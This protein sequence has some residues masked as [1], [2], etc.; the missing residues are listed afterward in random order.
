MGNLA[1]DFES[2]TDFSNFIGLDSVGQYLWQI[3]TN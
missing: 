3:N 2:K 1:E